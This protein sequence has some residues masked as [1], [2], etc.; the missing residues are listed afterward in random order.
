MREGGGR[1]AALQ[2]ERAYGI[3]ACTI[4]EVRMRGSAFGLARAGIQ[5]PVRNCQ[6]G[7]VRP[8]QFLHA[9]LPTPGSDR[10]IV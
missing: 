6:L 9:C 8:V 4:C 2:H 10:V 1:V 5:G 3:V 7:P